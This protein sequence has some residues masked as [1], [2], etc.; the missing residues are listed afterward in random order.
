MEHRKPQIPTGMQDTLPGECACKRRLEEEL[1][2]LFTLHGY[3]EIETPILEY[4]DVLDD[5]TYGYRPEH[6]WK[7]FDSRSCPCGCA[8]C[9]R[10]RTSSRTRCPCCAWSIR[11]GWS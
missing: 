5:Q 6:V 1:R 9:S 3:Q 11:P 4:Y 8:T 10:P 7:T 2:R